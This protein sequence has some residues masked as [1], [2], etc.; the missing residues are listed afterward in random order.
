MTLHQREKKLNV[1]DEDHE[2][3]E[4]VERGHRCLVLKIKM[5]SLL[6]KG[7]SKQQ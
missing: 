7:G 5:L 2:E 4:S 1:N 6:V 3:S